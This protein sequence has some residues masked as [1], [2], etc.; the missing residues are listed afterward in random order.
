M[1]SPVDPATPAT[2][3]ERAD[4]TAAAGADAAPAVVLRPQTLRWLHALGLAPLYVRRA[5]LPSAES[6]APSE[7]Y[8][9]ARAAVS[10]PASRTETSA[11]P[12]TRLG[13]LPAA[14]PVTRE[15][16]PATRPSTDAVPVRAAPPAAGLAAP[17]PSKPAGEREQAIAVMDW[18]QLRAAA[19]A[20]RACKLG[21]MRHRAVF[22]TGSV[23]A[24]WMIVGEA[25]GA[26]EDRQGEPFVGAAGQLLDQM[27]AS[28]GLSRSSEDPQHAVFI[29]NV[30]KCRPPANR[31]PLPDEVAVCA[32][33]L[34]RQVEL[35]QPRLILALGR[36]AAQTLLGSDAPISR[37]RGQVHRYAG[38]PTIV[39]YHPAYLLRNPA[40]KARV[41]RDL[42]LARDTFADLSA[43]GS[44]N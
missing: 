15:S 10:A 30:L 28:V 26:E 20:C 39:S 29:A 8:A 3:P 23:Q 9:P 22:G 18:A 25:P 1:S 7:P 33:I 32:P 36:F 42:C 34:R 37:L 38:V 16:A 44:P 4:P 41:W 12:T 13:T 6:A 11:A 31:N 14:A 21:A 35:L 27:L 17:A 5:L 2:A 40:D 19:D 24:R 43:D